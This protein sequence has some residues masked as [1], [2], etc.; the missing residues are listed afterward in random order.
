MGAAFGAPPAAMPPSFTA[1][2]SGGLDDLFDLG[3]GVGMPTGAYSPP[4]TVSVYWLILM[5]CKRD[6][7]SNETR[8]PLTATDTSDGLVCR[9][10]SQP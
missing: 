8:Q 10:G 2:A 3:A 4:K 7:M 1:P 5:T 6:A 9:F